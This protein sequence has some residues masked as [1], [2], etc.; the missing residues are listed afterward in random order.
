MSIQGNWGEGDWFHSG[1]GA[2]RF[3]QNADESCVLKQWD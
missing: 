3:W 1:V 2:G